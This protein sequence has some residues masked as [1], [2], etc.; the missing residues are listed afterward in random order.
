[1]FMIHFEY[2][3]RDSLYMEAY[4]GHG[5][6]LKYL[7]WEDFDE[8]FDDQLLLQRLGYQMSYAWKKRFGKLLRKTFY[9]RYMLKTFYV[10]MNFGR[11]ILSNYSLDFSLR[12]RICFDLKISF[13]IIENSSHLVQLESGRLLSFHHI[14]N[15]TEEVPLIQNCVLQVICFRSRCYWNK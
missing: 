7:N 10:T 5:W 3:N 12:E 8:L 11:K 4:L 2:I 13:Q 6:V 9:L 15:K 14:M 1:M